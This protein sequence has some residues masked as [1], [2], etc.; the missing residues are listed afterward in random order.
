MTLA[1][2]RRP[3]GTVTATKTVV[4]LTAADVTRNESNGT[5]RRY[6][7][8]AEASGEDTLRSPV[9]S[10]DFTWD[11]VIFPDDGSWTVHIRRVVGDT[12]DANLAVTVDP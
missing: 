10:G 3:T 7:M 5:E 8:T 1:I 9:F 2:T 11:N 4:H 12:S 6:Y